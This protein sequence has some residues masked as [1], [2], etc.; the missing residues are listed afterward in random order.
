MDLV[1]RV[2]GRIERIENSEIVVIEKRLDEMPESLIRDYIENN[3]RALSGESIERRFPELAHLPKP[4][5]LFFDTEN[6]GLSYEDPIFLI[7]TAHFVN[8][9]VGLKLLFARDYGEEQAIL[10]Y[11]LRMLP[12]YHGFFTFNGKTFDI[13]RLERRARLNGI[14][15]Q[16]S[17][18]HMMNGMHE[19]IYQILFKKKI[20]TGNSLQSAER[21]LFGFRRTDDVS[22]EAIPRAYLEYVYGRRTK[23]RKIPC[24]KKLLKQFEQKLIS[25]E[26]LHARYT[27]EG[28]KYMRRIELTDEPI[29][30]EQADERMARVINHNFYDVMSVVAVLAYLCREKTA[31]EPLDDVPF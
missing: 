4:Q 21:K 2:G 11:F 28:G 3:Q 23:V 17:I 14:P 8:G 30:L 6:C 18:G 29:N 31:P 25:G 7:G 27:R 20:L 12:N 9:S 1:E 22:G 26:D 10:S 16:N 15:I 24:D 13:P 5:M 19:D